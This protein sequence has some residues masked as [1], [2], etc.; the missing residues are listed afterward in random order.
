MDKTSPR[1]ESNSGDGK[2]SRRDF[3]KYAGVTG[4][5]LGL[6]VL[7]FTKIFDIVNATNNSVQ[8]NASSV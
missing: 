6:S 3:L 2:I 7:P 4:A 5:M 8:A 1:K